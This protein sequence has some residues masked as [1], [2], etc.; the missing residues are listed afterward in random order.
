MLAFLSRLKPTTKYTINFI[1]HEAIW[2]VKENNIDVIGNNAKKGEENYLSQI[3]ISTNCDAG[4]EIS[5][6][7]SL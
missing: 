6:T 3:E 1:D 7:K 4:N 5:M 2:K